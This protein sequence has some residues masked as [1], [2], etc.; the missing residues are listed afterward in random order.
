MTGLQEV[1]DE[2]VDE[3]DR[4]KKER[5]R[6]IGILALLTRFVSR[7]SPSARLRQD[8]NLFLIDQ[9]HHLRQLDD[10][11]Q[12]PLY[13]AGSRVGSPADRYEI[14]NGRRYVVA[15]LECYLR[16][17]P[18]AKPRD[19]IAKIAQKN[20][21]LKRLIRNATSEARFRNV[22]LESA[23]KRWRKSFREGSA[24]NEIQESWNMTYGSLSEKAYS[25]D[26]WVTAGNKSLKQAC[27]IAQRITLPPS[28]GIDPKSLAA[29]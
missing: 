25:T 16:A 18:T 20:S 11:I 3:E 26:R 19:E 23:I 9:I 27:A 8:V 22:Q 13:R 17:H 15:A 29:S 10:G 24:P 1:L 12:P 21:C 2:P 28:V 7:V 4:V 14:W 6:F 5:K